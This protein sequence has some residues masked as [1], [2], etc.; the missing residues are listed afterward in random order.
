MN[1]KSYMLHNYK[2]LPQMENLSADLTEAIEK[3]LSLS[4]L[5]MD[6]K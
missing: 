6:Y 5:E 4:K 1:Y 2:T 3:I